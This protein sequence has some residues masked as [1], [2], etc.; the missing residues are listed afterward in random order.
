MLKMTPIDALPL[1]LA[2]QTPGFGGGPSFMIIAYLALFVGIW[3]LLVA[4]QRKKQKEHDKMLAAL[5]S[6]DE[7]VTN[8]GIYGTITNVKDDRFVIKIAEGLKVEVGKGF[9]NTLVKRP[10]SED[11]S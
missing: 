10:G 2:Q 7:V 6:G 9:I 3:F 4:P 1:P 5:Q 8:G 11:K